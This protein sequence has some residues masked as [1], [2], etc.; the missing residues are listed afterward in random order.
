[1]FLIKLFGILIGVM[2]VLGGLK[3]YKEAEKIEMEI[4]AEKK[5]ADKRQQKNDKEM[6]L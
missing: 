6:G 1:M 5:A 4:Q 3:M 2:V